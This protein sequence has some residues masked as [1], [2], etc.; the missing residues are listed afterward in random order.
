MD[1][2]FTTIALL[3]LRDQNLPPFKEARMKRYNSIRKMIDLIDVAKRTCPKAPTHCLTL[4]PFDP[5]WDDDMTY[6]QVFYP[7]LMF[8]ATGLGINLWIYSYNYNNYTYNIRLRLMR[9][10]FPFV[11]VGLFGLIYADY[12]SQLLKVNLFDEYIQL[13]AKELVE[14]YE[15]LF[16]H[17]DLK[18]FF[19]W[20]EDFKE[21]LIRCHRQANN[22]EASDFKD[23]EII[24]QDFIRR[25]SNEKDAVPLP[26]GT[27]AAFW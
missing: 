23:S 13:R 24:L 5:E 21:T 11:H 26:F 2:Y 4:D 14:Q 16:E 19:Y 6:P 12:K 20:T 8:Q 17:E 22:H 27:R 25:Y 3:G 9:Y 10:L 15:F 1:N 7:R 18:K